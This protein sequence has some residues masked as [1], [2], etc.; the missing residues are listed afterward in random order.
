MGDD[1]NG[2]RSAAWLQAMISTAEREVVQELKEAEM[3]T[4]ADLLRL[5]RKGILKFI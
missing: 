4:D 3:L 2:Y 5:R 1:M